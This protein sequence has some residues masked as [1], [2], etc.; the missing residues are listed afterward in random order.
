MDDA[1]ITFN[2]AND[3]TIRKFSFVKEKIEWNSHLNWFKGKIDSEKC[4]YYILEEDKIP[5]GSVR[6]DVD[7]N[8]CGE[9]SY[10]IDPAYHGKGLGEFI[11]G[12][13]INRLSEMKPEIKSVSGMVFKENMPSV[14]VFEKLGFR[15]VSSDNLS[16]KFLK[17]L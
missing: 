10:L 2:W 15:I 12:S 3:P 13:G 9:I 4:F 17:K 16:V 6:F 7:S 11:L 5:I 14:R 8:Q 1:E